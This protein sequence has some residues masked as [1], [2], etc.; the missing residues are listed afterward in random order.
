MGICTHEELFLPISGQV[1]S[2]EKQRN[3]V[4]G[5]DKISTKGFS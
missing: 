1:T 3:K 5:A 4:C 2:M